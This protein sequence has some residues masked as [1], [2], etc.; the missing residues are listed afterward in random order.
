MCRDPDNARIAS[1]IDLFARAYLALEDLQTLES[2]KEPSERLLPGKGDQKTGLIGEY[3]GIRYARSLFPQAALEF[4]GHSQKGWDLKLAVVGQPPHYIQI[5][6]ASEFGRGK[7]SPIFLPSRLPKLDEGREL[8]DYWNE[9]WLLL[10]NKHFQPI[11]LWKI[12]PEHVDFSSS[13]CLSN[14][15]LR[16]DP[17]KPNT[18]SKCFRWEQAEWI[19]DLH[20]TLRTV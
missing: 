14:K 20:A 5:K 2:K 17:L 7:L 13:E 19:A 8:P 3:W 12:K 10:L 16:R 11:L 4:G 9:L 6:T 1:A 15:T 18:G